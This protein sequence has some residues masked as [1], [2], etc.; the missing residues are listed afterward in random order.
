VDVVP[1]GGLGHCQIVRHG[2]YCCAMGD[3]SSRAGVGVLPY[4]TEREQCL[5]IGYY[6]R[7]RF[8]H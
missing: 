3:V 5:F 4:T 8:E 2:A 7:H 6:R 1:V